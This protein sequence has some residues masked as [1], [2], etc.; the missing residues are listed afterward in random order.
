M[1][2]KMNT[3]MKM[4]RQGDVLF[5]SVNAVPAGNRM[6]RENGHILAGEVTGHIHRISDLDAAEV[7]EIGDRLFLSVRAGGVSIV[8]EDHRA[9]ELPPGDFEVVRQREYT[10]DAIR[11]VCD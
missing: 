10:P 11:N 6:K 4:Y 3:E 5:R 8:H 9:I 7:F 2:K 1:E